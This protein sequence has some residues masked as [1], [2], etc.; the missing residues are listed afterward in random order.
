MTKQ[1]GSI[2][3]LRLKARFRGDRGTEKTDYD[4]RRR[5]SQ[6]RFKWLYRGTRSSDN[7]IV[8][9]CLVRAQRGTEDNEFIELHWEMRL[10]ISC[11]QNINR[12]RP[13]RSQ[14][15]TV[16]LHAMSLTKETAENNITNGTYLLMIMIDDHDIYHLSI[17]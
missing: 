7:N 8:G 14:L 3:G 5:K 16:R 13:M 4:H 9:F 15:L 10:E 12:L 2:D 11:H 6:N 1:N 17:L